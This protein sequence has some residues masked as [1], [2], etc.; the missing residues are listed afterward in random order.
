[1]Y[2]GGFE[3]HSSLVDGDHD[4]LF[5]SDN[6]PITTP[7]SVSLNQIHFPK[8]VKISRLG[9][10]LFN[11]PNLCYLGELTYYTNQ[12]VIY[13]EIDG[14]PIKNYNDCGMYHN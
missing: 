3:G 9:V 8:L 7:S 4:S 14:I 12:P 1:M 11:N 6:N 13:V 10:Y 2:I 5:I